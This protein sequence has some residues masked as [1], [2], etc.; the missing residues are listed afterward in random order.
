MGKVNIGGLVIIPEIGDEVHIV[1]RVPAFTFS[2][3]KTHD[4]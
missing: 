4:I 2:T 1:R 3:S